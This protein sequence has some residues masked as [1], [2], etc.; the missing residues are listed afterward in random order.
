MKRLVFL[1]VL[2]GLSTASMAQCAMC[3]T[4]IVNNVSNG[5]L[6]LADGLNYGIMMLF[7]APYLLILTV[8]G[9]WYY[10][11]KQHGREKRNQRLVGV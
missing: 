5:Q 7:V 1:L 2:L 11:Y 4:T 6:A 3:K 8:A 10:K 9:I